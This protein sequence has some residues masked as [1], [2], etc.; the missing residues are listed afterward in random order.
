VRYRCGQALLRMRTANPALAAPP[1]EVFS[2]AGRELDAGA[3]NGRVVE[4]VFTL[5]ALGLDREPLST[6]LWAL[7]YGDPG[8]RGTALEYLDNVLPAPLKQ[9]L[10]PHLGDE[11]PA[12]RG[13]S[14]QE[15]R[16]D[17]LRST[18]AA[19]R[20]LRSRSGVQAAE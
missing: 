16:E 20:R 2:A 10:W 5:L 3:R 4:H 11:R 17:L 19:G 7:R 1:A 8:L 12:S 6:C 9:A 13:R 14:T 15:I 18:A